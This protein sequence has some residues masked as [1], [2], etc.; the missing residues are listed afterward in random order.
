MGLYGGEMLISGP[1]PVTIRLAIITWLICDIDDSPEKYVVRVL[2]PGE[3]LPRFIGTFNFPPAPVDTDATKTHLRAN[4]QLEG[5]RVEDDG[6]ITVFVETDSLI[7]R[8]GRLKLRFV[9]K[10][11][12]DAEP[13]RVSN[14]SLPP[15]R[16]SRGA[17][18]VAKRKRAPSRPSRRRVLPKQSR[19][20]SFPS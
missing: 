6:L 1:K 20:G 16:Q 19:K 14:E 2:G 4:L 3:D 13:V 9:D 17:A 5:L 10:R 18:S 8:A 15:S 12:E 7:I 11:P